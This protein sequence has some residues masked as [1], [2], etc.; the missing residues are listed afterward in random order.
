MF[1]KNISRTDNAYL[2]ICDGIGQLSNESIQSL[3][4][5]DVA[6]KPKKLMLFG[7]WFKLRNNPFELSKREMS[8]VVCV[9]TNADL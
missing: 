8:K 7:Q 3:G 4:I 6:D 9:R 1:V 2:I 5:I